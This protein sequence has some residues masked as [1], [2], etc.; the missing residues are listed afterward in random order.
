[1]PTELPVR[2]VYGVT[3][4]VIAAVIGGPLATGFLM[5]HNFNIFKE[6]RAVV[7]SW[8]SAVFGVVI[9]FL[10]F[11]YCF[12]LGIFWLIPV[13]NGVITLLLLMIFQD[14]KLVTYHASDGPLY[15]WWVAI[16]IGI[17]ALGVCYFLGVALAVIT[18][19]TTDKKMIF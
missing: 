11:R 13:L 18:F 10:T 17:G 4:I 14:N 2:K 15:N 1:M 7:I 9:I 3:A 16:V 19:F 6:F 5:A 12:D 8:I